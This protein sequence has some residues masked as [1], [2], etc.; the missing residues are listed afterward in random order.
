MVKGFHLMKWHY[1]QLA[2]L[3]QNLAGLHGIINL[4]SFL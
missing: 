1:S 4:G 3:V 2:G